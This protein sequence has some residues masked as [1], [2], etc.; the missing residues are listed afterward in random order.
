MDAK[1]VEKVSITDS[2]HLSA[3]RRRHR[4]IDKHKKQKLVRKR[5]LRDQI[6][7]HDRIDLLMTEVLDYNLLQD[8]HM[9]MWYHRKHCYAAKEEQKWHLALAPRGGGKSTILTNAEI[10]LDILKFPN[11]RIL[12]ASKTD[13]NSIGFL[14]EIKQKMESK[15]FI[16]IFG[17]L[18]GKLWN[19][20]EITI[21]T[22]TKAQKEPTISTVGYTGALA[23][24]HFEK[25]YADDLVDEENSKTEVQREKLKTWLFKVLDPTLEPDGDMN[26]IG[27]RY[28]PDDLYGELINTVF[29]KKSKKTGK[30]KKKYYIR[31]P[32]LMKKKKCKR[33]LPEY[34][35][36][37]SFWPDKFSVKFLLKKK[38]DQG[39]IIFNSQMQNDVEAMK[40]KIFKIDWFE[41]YTMEDIDIKKLRI[42][43]GVD[44]AIKQ[45]ENADKFA[46]CTIGVCPK[47]HNVYILDYYNR[48]THYTKQKQVIGEKFHKYDPVRVAVEANGYQS[49]LLQD[50]RCDAKL[51]DVR[52]VPVFTDT[53]KTTR[54]WKL[55]AY[56]ER[57]QIF[58]LEG[59]HVMQQHLL[60]M[61]DGR[62]KDLFDALDIAISTA[63]GRKK[64]NRKEEP[65][66]I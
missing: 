43:Q 52:A 45:K 5:W 36:Y 61:P 48:V 49:A 19:D 14:R 8:F 2:K 38:K 64:S 54:A 26:I 47:T 34:K 59:M 9:L 41:W 35:K 23:S 32:A 7:N 60:K 30:V 37:T 58:L 27:T 31:I 39:T 51:A 28:H 40:G 4:A 25:I 53:D 17:N 13:T 65:G 11:I 56:F 42:F 3:V 66:L 16:S 33:S 62:Y 44:L 63:F 55:S 18:K 15:K 57:G 46:H 21:N 24:R 6:I 1:K 20:S 29:T 50:M 10:I 22:R 12:I